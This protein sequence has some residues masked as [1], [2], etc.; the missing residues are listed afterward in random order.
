VWILLLKES[1]ENI[2][3]GYMETNKFRKQETILVDLSKQTFNE[4]EKLKQAFFLGMNY[5]GELANDRNYWK[6]WIKVETG[7]TKIEE[8]LHDLNLAIKRQKYA[9]GTTKQMMKQVR[10]V[11][12]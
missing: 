9:R 1:L 11:E 10:Q 4:Q 12:E 6:R 2:N 7:F 3:G 8:V 5:Q